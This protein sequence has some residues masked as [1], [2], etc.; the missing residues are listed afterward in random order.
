MKPI[1][2]AVLPVAGFGTRV[3]PATKAV[4]KEMLTVFD[5]P[6]LQYVVDEAREAGIDL[7]KEPSQREAWI[8]ALAANPRAIQRPI[9][10]ATDGTTVVSVVSRDSTSPVCRVSKKTGRWRSTL[11]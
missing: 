7:P 3:L 10:T 2:K 1:R 5:R 4:P 8:A 11:A 6:A 9:I